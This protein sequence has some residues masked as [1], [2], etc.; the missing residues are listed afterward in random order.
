MLKPTISVICPTRKRL[1]ELQ[2]MVASLK[3]TATS[4]AVELIARI[5][6]DDQESYPFLCLNEIPFIV[7]PRRDGYATLATLINEGARLA[8]SDL[9]LVINDDVTFDTVGWD[10]RLAEHGARFPD[11][12]FNIGVDVEN[13]GNFVFPCVSR[14]LIE[15]LGGVFD[16]RLVYPD[17]WLRDVLMPF[18]RAVRI[19]DVRLSHHWKGQTPDQE[20]AVRMRVSS[21]GYEDL[22][23]RCVLE[24]QA[25]IS[26]VLFSQGTRFEV[27]Q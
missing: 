26:E 1:A 17:I 12:I 16:E 2:R 19:H 4:G 5:D 23:Q 20:H 27:V 14:R 25:K 6:F 7:G 8:T 22:Y 9:V 15:L 3:A 24:G 21:Y 13:A 11:G 18:H 10:Q